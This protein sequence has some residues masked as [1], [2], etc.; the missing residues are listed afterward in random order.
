MRGRSQ[1]VF[2]PHIDTVASQITISGSVKSSV[3]NFDSIKATLEPHACI[4]W[5][6]T[7]R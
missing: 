4:E 7:I 3:W 2:L 1:M 6:M 5:T